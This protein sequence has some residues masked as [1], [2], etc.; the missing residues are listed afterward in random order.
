ML[1]VPGP[2]NVPFKVVGRVTVTGWPV[3]VVVPFMKRS[4][5]AAEGRAGGQRDVVEVELHAG[6]DGNETAVR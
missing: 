4:A 5:A 1:S 2:V 3:T 6:G